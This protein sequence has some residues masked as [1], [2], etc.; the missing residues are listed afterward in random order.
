MQLLR[1]IASWQYSL[2]CFCMTATIYVFMD[3]PNVSIT[4]QMR[5]RAKIVTSLNCLLVLNQ[6]RVHSPQKSSQCAD[7]RE[8]V[9]QMSSMSAI[10][11]LNYLIDVMGRAVST[12]RATSKFTGHILSYRLELF[13][14][15]SNN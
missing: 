2:L 13:I 8:R 14:L 3:I 12:R 5:K 15:L 6:I 11:N 9:L 7:Y 10:W 1:Q 4:K